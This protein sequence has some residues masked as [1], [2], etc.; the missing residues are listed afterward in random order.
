VNSGAFLTPELMARVYG[1]QKS[2][3]VD[4]PSTRMHELRPTDIGRQLGP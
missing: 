1:C 2:T 3:G 4:G